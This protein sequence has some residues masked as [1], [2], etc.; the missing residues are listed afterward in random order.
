MTLDMARTSARRRS[1]R[2]RRTSLGAAVQLAL[3]LAASSVSASAQPLAPCPVSVAPGVRHEHRKRVEPIWIADGREGG[4]SLR[5]LAELGAPILWFSPRE[6]LLRERIAATTL[7]SPVGADAGPRAV[8]YRIR[9]VRLKSPAAGPARFDHDISAESPILRRLRDIDAPWGCAAGGSLDGELPLQEL[10]QI[11][12]RYFFYYPED[13]GIGGHAHDIESLELRLRVRPTCD[14]DACYHSVQVE[15]ASGSAHGVGWYTNV[16]DVTRA[17]DTQIP[18]TVIVEENKHASSPDRDG[19]G[20]YM[21]HYDL[22]RFSNDG[23][24]IRDV[25][26]TGKLGSPAFTADQSRVL[27]ASYPQYRALP[28][29]RYWSPRLERSFRRSEKD[30]QRSQSRGWFYRLAPSWEQPV[31]KDGVVDDD[32][33][34][35]RS[36]DIESRLGPEKAADAVAKF[37]DLATKME[38]CR[39]PSEVR[40]YSASIAGRQRLSDI[41]SLVFPGP[42]NQFGFMSWPQRMA[43]AYRFDHVA[44]GASYV[45][46][47]L[48]GFEMPVFG[49]WVVTRVNVSLENLRDLDLGAVSVDAMYMPSASRSATWYVAIGEE[50]RSFDR[51]DEEGK[52]DIDRR[53]GVA[54]EIGV[55]FRFSLEKFKIVKF[56]GARVGVR[57]FGLNPIRDPRLVFEI[58]AGSW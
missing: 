11:V 9:E 58:G 22:N 5:K 20:L 45:G 55:K 43:G 48:P 10:D 50:W 53:H 56:Y 33:V 12:I 35:E 46:P 16:L 51:P 37:R 4:L 44:T 30:S 49:G 8:F 7:P 21:P 3:A 18:L 26:G 23:W 17:H 40:V 1:F 36:K 13:R 24:G 32:A 15:T 28:N 54:E 57:A 47:F 14:G 52:V 27:R 31:C 41:A 38:F 2:W 19:D 6:F 29:T 34:A 39:R 25:A 42:R